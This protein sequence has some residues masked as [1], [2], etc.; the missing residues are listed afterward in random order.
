MKLKYT[1]PKEIEKII[2]SL[3]SKTS[4]GYD[5]IPMKIL[6]LSTPFI[7]SPLSYICNKSL[8]SGIFPKVINKERERI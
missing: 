5:G 7:T 2:R 4:L 8:S 6:K 1:T 3:K